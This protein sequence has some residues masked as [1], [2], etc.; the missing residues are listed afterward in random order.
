MSLEL[1]FP[2]TLISGASLSGHDSNEGDAT[3]TK[4]TAGNKPFASERCPRA[5]SPAVDQGMSYPL[6][7]AL[8]SHHTDMFQ[9]PQSERD[10]LKEPAQGTP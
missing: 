3:K 1:T 8:L 4:A 10:T 6:P 7:S 5:G 9:D 2:V